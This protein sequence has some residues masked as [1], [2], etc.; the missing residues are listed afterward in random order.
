MLI[1]NAPFGL[2]SKNLHVVYLVLRLLNAELQRENTGLKQRLDEHGERYGET[3]SKL[4]ETVRH[5]R[6]L[7][8][9]LCDV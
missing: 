1:L 6:F 4:G 9:N 2:C 7:K 3:S 8:I 5:T